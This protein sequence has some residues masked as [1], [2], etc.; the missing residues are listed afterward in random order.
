MMG[1]YFFACAMAIFSLSLHAQTEWDFARE[2]RDKQAESMLSLKQAL[3]QSQRETR[4]ERADVTPILIFV[5]FSMPE[6]SIEAYL[7]DAKKKN[8]T[9]V[10]QG[11]IN[12]SFQQTFQKIG[13]LVRETDGSGIALNP[14]W[15]KKFAITQVPAIVV[16]T[17][18]TDCLDNESC[19][20]N[21]DFDLIKGDISLEEALRQVRDKGIAHQTASKVLLKG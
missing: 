1:K 16:L 15:F 11:L 6:K 13:A 17:P 18:D 3:K 14:L 20:A 2:M 7:R 19:D 10:I 4:T 9:V 12:N 8:A 21:H 5:S